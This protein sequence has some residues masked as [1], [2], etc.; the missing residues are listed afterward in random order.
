MV[1]KHVILGL[2]WIIYC[3]V[4]SFFASTRVKIYLEKK[5]G[6]F[7]RY[8]R[9]S[10]SLFAAITLA[11]LIYFQY[12]IQSVL[13][14]NSSAIGNLALLLFVI[15][16]FI[17][18]C[19]SIYKYF[20]LLS[21]IRSLYH[22]KQT[23]VLRVDGIHQYMRHPLYSGTLLFLFGIF[24]IFPLLS[25]FISVCIIAMYVVA[26]VSLEERKL[27]LEFGDSYKIY[28]SKVPMLIP[29]FRKNTK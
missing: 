20:R 9:L 7:F 25:N 23:S 3:V 24:L 10:Y 16:G 8:Y 6:Y 4:H 12:K 2:L 14:F 15:P 19:M 28:R 13:L 5:S 11:L 29:N 17:L 26:G 18:M 22:K 1:L 27:L 21:G